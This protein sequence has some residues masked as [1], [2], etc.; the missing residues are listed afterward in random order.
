MRIALCADGRSPHAQRWA[1]GLAERGLGVELV[2]AKDDLVVADLDGL[3]PSISHHVHVTRSAQL[4]PWRGPVVSRRARQLGRDLRPDLVHGFYLATHG[5][6]ARAL[7]VRPL[8]LSALG[9]DV[10]RLR[11]GGTDGLAHRIA[12]AYSVRL[13]RAAVAAADLVL[14]DSTAIADAVRASV[15]ETPTEI[16]RFGVELTQPSPASR[17]RWRRRLDIDDGSFVLLSSR[18]VQPR[19]NI[20]A[21]I[22][23]LPAIASALPRS[24]LVLKELPRFS[25]PDYRR[26]C[27]AL[28]D[29][30]GVS[31]RVRTVGELDRSELLE[32]YGAADVYLSVPETDGTAVSVLEAMAAGVAVVA[33]DAPGIDPEILRSDETAL[34]VPAE[35][36]ALASAVVSLAL[37]DARRQR[38]VARAREV[39]R[40][41]GDFDRELD[42]AVGIYERLVAEKRASA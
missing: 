26:R 25:D 6:T 42:R 30:L 9:T 1:N 40:V 7:G 31:E 17:G 10:L 32:L 8:V 22:R 33:T 24:V 16:V 12:D 14:A 3:H 38:L 37:D 19:Y 34:L 18:L 23:A 35:G 13:T 28:A 5:W 41:H 20:D 11:R 27:F 15:P 39:V 21:I 2:W 4:R 29:E 36:E